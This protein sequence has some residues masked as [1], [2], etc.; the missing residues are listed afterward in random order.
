MPSVILVTG[1]PGC[2]KSTF[3]RKHVL[4][5]L[6]RWPLRRY[7]RNP[8]LYYHERELPG[9]KVI[10]VGAYAFPDDPCWPRRRRGTTPS[11]PGTDTLQPQATALLA[12][13][14]AGEILGA[15]LVI[16][17]ACSARKLTARVIDAMAGAESLT[18]LELRVERD[19]AITR[20]EARDRTGDGQAASSLSRAELFDT[21]GAQVAAIKA[22]ILSRT[23]GAAAWHVG[24]ADDVQHHIIS[25]LA[26]R[27]EGVFEAAAE[28][29]QQRQHH[30]ESAAAEVAGVAEAEAEP[31]AVERKRPRQ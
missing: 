10:V 15:S 21:Y 16:L 19:V 20:L 8:Q 14:C 26:R 9:G 22:K 25:A 28:G 27:A 18:V 2:G 31:A 6:A 17:E 1:A 11:A 4:A 30:V 12:Q 29:V 5:D 23:G 13:L 24:A 7:G 3:M